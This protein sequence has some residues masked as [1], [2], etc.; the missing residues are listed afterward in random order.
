MLELLNSDKA[1]AKY[2]TRKIINIAIRTTYYIF[3]SRNKDWT[4]PD[5]MNF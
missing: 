2:I 3:C 5:L 1:H 4:N